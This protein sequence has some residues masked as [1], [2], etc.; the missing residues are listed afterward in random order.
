MAASAASKTV[1]ADM[2]NVDARFADAVSDKL[3]SERNQMREYLIRAGMPDTES[4]K[5]YLAE[6]MREYAYWL[7]VAVPFDYGWDEDSIEAAMRKHLEPKELKEYLTAKD[8]AGQPKPTEREDIRYYGKDTENTA[9]AY[10]SGELNAESFA[11]I[12]EQGNGADT[13]VIAA[14]STAW[15]MQALQSRSIFYLETGKEIQEADLSDEDTVI[16]KMQTVVDKL[17]AERARESMDLYQRIR[18]SVLAEYA[19]FEKTAEKDLPYKHRFY[20]AVTEYFEKGRANLLDENDMKALEKDKG[21]ILAR[22]YD[23]DWDGVAH[24]LSDDAEITVLIEYYNENKVSENA[25]TED[26]DCAKSCGKGLRSFIKNT[27]KT[28]PIMRI[29]QAVMCS[30]V[31]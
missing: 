24:D 20:Q 13:F 29:I 27:N 2:E 21:S 17:T 5:P 23:Y 11:K 9:Y 16:G 8:S 30:T 31:I 12:A 7:N 28:I 25:G 22:L 6:G 26:K 15:D 4:M 19:D 10:V 1:T 3:F 18:D 14:G